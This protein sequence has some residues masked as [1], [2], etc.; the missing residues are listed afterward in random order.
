[1]TS[2]VQVQE[3]PQRPLHVG[4][5]HVQRERQLSALRVQAVTITQQ[6]HHINAVEAAVGQLG[7]RGEGVLRPAREL[8][9]SRNHDDIMGA[10]AEERMDGACEAGGARTPVELAPLP[11]SR[12]DVFQARRGPAPPQLLRQRCDGRRRAVEVRR[13]QFPHAVQ[14]VEKHGHRE[15]VRPSGLRAEGGHL[16]RHGGEGAW[17]GDAEDRAADGG[18]AGSAVARPGQLDRRPAACAHT[19]PII[20]AVS[21]NPRPHQSAWLRGS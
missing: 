12:V 3:R 16:A 1:M 11:R 21:T 8:A 17:V 2:P 20:I 10:E 7:R 13:Q 4:A 14:R 5:V 15:E 18:G 6:R 9:C 19:A